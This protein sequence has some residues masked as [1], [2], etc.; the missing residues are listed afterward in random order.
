MNIWNV[1]QL[2]YVDTL[3]GHQ[4][5]ALA[6][7]LLSGSKEKYITTCHATFQIVTYGI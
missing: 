2:S 3:F 4:S 1:D 6:I 5:E 7:D